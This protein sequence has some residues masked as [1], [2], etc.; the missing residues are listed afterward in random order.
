M[1]ELCDRIVAE[2]LDISWASNSR[3]DTVNPEVLAAM[4]RAGCWLVAFGVEKGTNEALESINKKATIE[5][6]LVAL[7]MTREAGL[8]RSIY[9]LVGLPNDNEESIAKDI[10]FAKELDPDYLEIFYPYPFPGT[11]LYKEAVAEGLLEDG[12]IPTEAYG[13]PA[14]PTKHLTMEKLA[15]IRTESLR[16]FYMRP[17]FIARTLSQT[18]STKEFFNYMKYGYMQ[19][20]QILTG[21]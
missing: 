21:A 10:E 12:S 6:A 11:P 17:S 8:R 5:Q 20:R 3:V 13:L 14:M 2:K 1:I 4:K 9:I 18:R 16:R 19:F 15:H 7:K